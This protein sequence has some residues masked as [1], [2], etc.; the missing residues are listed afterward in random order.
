MST[1][2][3][4][5]LIEN[6]EFTCLTLDETLSD[7]YEPLPISERN[8]ELASKRLARWIEISADG[9]PEVFSR[10]LELTSLSRQ[11]ILDRFGG[12][13]R[14]PNRNPPSW[15]DDARLV[16]KLLCEETVHEC[17]WQDTPFG[18]LLAPI[19]D[20]Y[21][22]S[23]W[24]QV[25]T[26]SISAEARRTIEQHL[27]VQ[28]SA[29]C[30]MPFYEKML[31]WRGER[32]FQAESGSSTALTQLLSS[33][34][35]DF[36]IWFKGAGMEGLVADCPVLFRLLATVISQWLVS[37]RT[38]FE[39]LNNDRAEIASLLG[40]PTTNLLVTSVQWGKSDPHNGGHSVLSVKFDGHS[41]MYYKPK[42]LRADILFSEFLNRMKTSGFHL[43]LLLP[44]TLEKNGYGWSNEVPIRECDDESD[45]SLYYQR[46]GAWLA[47]FHVLAAS[48]MHM[49]NFIANGAFPV[50]VDFEM[51]LQS[52]RQRPVLTSPATEAEWLATQ[53][54]EHSVQSTGMLPSYVQGAGG[55]LISL[56]ALEPSVYSVQRIQW[57][58]LN[59]SGMLLVN[60]KEEV[61]IRSNLPTLHGQS[62]SIQAF[63]EDFLSGFRSTLEFFESATDKLSSLVENAELTLRRVIRPTRYYY[64][65]MK[66]LRDHRRMAD[67]LSWSFEADFSA[68]TFDW[69]DSSEQ[70][71]KLLASERRQ[72]CSLDIPHFVM[73]S[74]SNIISDRQGPITRLH[75]DL[76]RDVSAKRIS[77]IAETIR[78]QEIITRASLQMPIPEEVQPELFSGNDAAKGA[79]RFAASIRDDILSRAFRSERAM[80]WLGIN[81]IDHDTAAQ[82]GPIGYDLYQGSTGIALFLAG[83]SRG[84]DPDA[85][86]QSI[87][88]LGGV[89][90]YA[91]NGDL[92]RLT[93]SIGIGGMVGIGSIV[94][95]LS[96]VAELLDY[97]PA[98]QAAECFAGAVTDDAIKADDRFDVVAGSAGALLSLLALSRRSGSTQWVEQAI[99]CAE[100]LMKN[101]NPR[102]GQWTSAAFGMPLT[103]FAHGAAGMALAMSKLYRVTSDERYRAAALVAVDFEN[104]YF[105]K[106]LKNWLDL[107]PTEVNGPLR[108]PDQW[109][110]GATGIGLARSAMLEDRTVSSE[111]LLEDIA[112]S[113]DHV[114]SSSSKTDSLCCGTAGK[115]EMLGALASYLPYVDTLTTMKAKLFELEDRWSSVKDFRWN[116]GTRHFNPGLFQGMSGIGL[117]AL[118]VAAVRCPSPL[119]LE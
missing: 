80:A 47:I 59:T 9:D 35:K 101:R 50:P 19:L 99:K 6:F 119:I 54:L 81:R 79:L 90:H 96:V 16:I 118:R 51:L 77:A 68:R 106:A 76:G 23:L 57:S 53:Y 117:S 116:G 114:C 11:Q 93:R 33:D 83:L 55:E 5:S 34:L 86:E 41:T 21:S 103:G 31:E 46:F 32:I 104:I 18:P 39:R 40:R 2:F 97:E 25:D 62:V 78:D 110:Y 113:I 95:G 88:A 7:N 42:D 87:A 102:D 17:R 69:Q 3:F 60:K 85:R 37:Y 56:G 109:C 14:K 112:R 100:H 65:L 45:V 64:M 89:I 1:S 36:S 92:A 70:P 67:G 72:L 44:H 12:V 26:C 107:R 115:I 63:R 108:S 49:E 8:S 28:I 58:N 10:R 73:S 91:E 74:E 61:N 38:F 66:R 4:G 98:L 20:H 75:V 52:P 22:K 30:E 43:E 111:A 29:L 105:D 27:A 82:L 24:A 15:Y 48:D 13:R 84:G 94:Y 71:W